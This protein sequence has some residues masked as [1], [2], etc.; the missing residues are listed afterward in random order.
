MQVM[1]N[2]LR[3]KYAQIHK[4][5]IAREKNFFRKSR[6]KLINSAICVDKSKISA[7]RG[8]MLIDKSVI[9]KL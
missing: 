7:S 1:S 8:K 3:R 4:N 5:I 9:I 6:K 2:D